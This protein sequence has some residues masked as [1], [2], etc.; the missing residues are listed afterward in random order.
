[1]RGRRNHRKSWSES[2]HI[3][4]EQNIPWWLCQN[5]PL[6][7]VH[8]WLWAAHLTAKKYSSIPVSCD[9]GGS[10][11]FSVGILWM[12]LTKISNSYIFPPFWKSN[13]PGTL[14]RSYFCF[15]ASKWNTKWVYEEHWRIGFCGWAAL[16]CDHAKQ[17]PQLLRKSCIYNYPGFQSVPR[18]TVPWLPSC[19]LS[20]LKERQCSPPDAYRLRPGAFCTKSKQRPKR[21]SR[22][23]EAGWPDGKI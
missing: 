16:Q 13:F 1:M 19:P 20:I 14:Q 4:W 15:L 18:P 7:W 11:T 17:D 9:W 23:Q 12:N 5:P 10:G 21:P 3:P 2:H 6:T 8:S 22:C